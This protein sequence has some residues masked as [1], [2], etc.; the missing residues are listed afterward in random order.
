MMKQA[1]IIALGL[2]AAL[3]GCATQPPPRAPT[4]SVPV[5]CVDFSFP[6]YFATNSEQLTP[7]AQQ[8]IAESAARVRGCKLGEIMV[9]GLADADGGTARTNLA[10]SKR[11]AASVAKALAA[12]GLPAPKFDIEAGGASGALTPGGQPE[13]LRRR[14][15]VVI[16]AEPPAKH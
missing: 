10:L 6:I 11:R 4:P 16:H 2:G 7:A 14:T 12:G 15:E 1:S 8:I 13:P 5:T 9:M 3:A